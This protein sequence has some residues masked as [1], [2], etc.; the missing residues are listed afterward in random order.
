[1]LVWNEQNLIPNDTPMPE[2]ENAFSQ[3]EEMLNSNG[4]ADTLEFLSKKLESEKKYFELFEILKMQTRNDLSLPI[5]GSGT[6][7]LSE[8]KQRQ[9]EDALFDACEKVGKLLMKDGQVRE[10]WAYLRPVGKIDEVRELVEA[11]EVTDENVDAIVEV[12]LS[13]GVSPEYGFGIV[14]ERYGTCNS[15]TTY[16][17]EISRRSPE[18]Q[19]SAAQMLVEH[20]HEELTANVSSDVERQQGKKPT[21]ETLKELID[22][23][24]WLFEGNAYHVDTTHLASVIRFARVLED[25]DALRT[26]IDLA[27]YGNQLSEQY[28]YDGDEPFKDLYPSS[29]LFLKALVGES[30]E[31]ATKYFA[32]KAENVDAYYDGTIAIEYYIG[33][34]ARTNQHKKA[35]E[36]S[37]RLLPDGPRVGIAPTLFD[38]SQK[39][40]SYD[41]M[42]S[43]YREKNDLLGYALGLLNQKGSA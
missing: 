12:A 37:I 39:A 28:H 8:E 17:A 23:R 1:M 27:E 14:L 36:E 9:L 22:D 38:L 6:E 42:L 33:L 35:I 41:D 43:F 19:R 20:L 16:D 40:D 15:I 10:A 31:E 2:T 25:K 29:L 11:I 32:E 24:D 3:I 4:I 30:V 26:A 34:L 5:S 21:E 13:E 7:N 18:D